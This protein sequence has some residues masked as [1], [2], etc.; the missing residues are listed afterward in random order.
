MSS[1]HVKVVG[2]G[3][4]AIPAALRRKH[5][6]DVGRTLVVE[7][8]VGSVTI[9]SLDEAVAA[10]QAIM[11]RVAPPERMLSDELI[12]ERRVQAARE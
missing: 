10:A 1:F 8:G 12:A 2:G 11:A 9:R 7:D 3:K 4:I 5:G 6:F